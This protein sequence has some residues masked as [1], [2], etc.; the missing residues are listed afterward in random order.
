M[1]KEIVQFIDYRKFLEHYYEEQKRV[2]RNFSYRYFALKAGI[3]SA[4]FLK[5]VI[6]GKRNLSPKSI[7]QFCK[8]INFNAK[9]ARYFTH[10]VLFNQ[11]KTAMEKQEYY[12]VLRTLSGAVK[13]D[14]LK[15]N[16]YDYYDKWYTSILRELL[17]LHDF[18][19][20]YDLIAKTV[21]PPITN[22]EA[23]KAVELLL[24]LSLIAVNADGSYKQTRTAIKADGAM[25]SVAVRNFMDTMLEHAK[26][27]LH[28]MDKSER[29]I[30]SI[31]LGISPAAYAILV[32][33]IQAF[34]DRVKAIVNKDEDSSRVYHLNL[35]LFPGSKTV[36]PPAPVAP[37]RVGDR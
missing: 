29:H 14:T 16:Q 27:A 28:G 1:M 15:N 7:E 35:G 4:S 12:A 31:T 25:T 17:C 32:E 9:D 3:A 30:S 18:Q 34:K 23:K 6:E 22:F 33:E 11:A 13:E 8:A 37:T 5:A 24:K 19:N 20:D 2:K 21:V 10:L 26:K 36:K